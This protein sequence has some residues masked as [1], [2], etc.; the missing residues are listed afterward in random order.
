MHS[1]AVKDMLFDTDPYFLTHLL[2]QTTCWHMPYA[3]SVAADQTA[4][5][6]ESYTAANL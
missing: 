3:D 4:V 1:Y 2:P 6:H 5:W